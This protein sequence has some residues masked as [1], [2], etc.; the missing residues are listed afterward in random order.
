MPGSKTKYSIEYHPKVVK[1]DIPKLDEK[2][3]DI[4]ERKIDKLTE[5]PTL[6]TPLRGKLA[7]CYRL[8]VSK[9]RIVYKIYDEKLIILVIAIGKRENLFVY[10]TAEKRT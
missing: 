10:K 2:I 4:I 1:D 7:G 5:E 9:Y 3:K 8:K 6:G